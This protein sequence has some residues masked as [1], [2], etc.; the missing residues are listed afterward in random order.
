MRPSLLATVRSNGRAFGA[1]LLG[2]CVFGAAITSS[3]VTPAAAETLLE[4]NGIAITADDVKLAESDI[5]PQLA[6][7]PESDRRRVVVE[8]LIDNMLL[9]SAAKEQKMGETTRY[10]DRVAY[11]RKRALRDAYFQRFVTEQ[12]SPDQVRQIYD[13][14]TAS[15]PAGEE[16]R[17]RHILVKTEAEARDVIE[18]LNRGGAFSDVAR[19]LSIGPSAQQGGD[20]GYFG[21][22][23]MV[24]P[25]ETAAFAMQKGQVSEPV[26]TQFGWHVIK[27]EDRRKR[28]APPFELMKDRIY[29]GLL[30]NQA[31][32]VIEKLR[33]G[34]KVDFKDKQLQ[35]QIAEAARGS[36][37]E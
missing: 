24:K 1:V 31:Q 16:L 9:A 32:T 19:E 22:D 21:K 3:T 28:Q 30:E 11:Y 6:T 18:R 2:T 14:Q 29:A 15:I 26:Q 33:A 20:L 34:A 35:A 7:I 17:A 8:Y 5:G 27:L 23:Q 13:R 10:Q 36:A 4:V 37:I 25:F 12:V